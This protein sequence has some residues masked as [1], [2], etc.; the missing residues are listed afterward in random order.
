VAKQANPAVE[1]WF[2]AQAFK[3]PEWD[4]ATFNAFTKEQLAAAEGYDHI[5]FFG[6][7]FVSEIDTSAAGMHFGAET[8]AL[9]SKYLKAQ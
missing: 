7:Q 6:W 8:K 1:T 5:L 4:T 3:M 9:F 2:I